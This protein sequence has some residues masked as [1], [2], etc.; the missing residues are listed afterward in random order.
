M[1]RYLLTSEPVG[2]GY[3][4]EDYEITVHL[5]LSILS[6]DVKYL[7]C[8]LQFTCSTLRLNNFIEFEFFFVSSNIYRQKCREI[9]SVVS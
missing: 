4:C 1:I 9:R 7:V 6:V 3:T 2:L 5:I 8:L